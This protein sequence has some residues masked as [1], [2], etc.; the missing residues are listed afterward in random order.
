MAGASRERWKIALAGKNYVK[1]KLGVVERSSVSAMIII[2][3]IVN[4]I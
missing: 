1:Q 4:I 2:I 3:I